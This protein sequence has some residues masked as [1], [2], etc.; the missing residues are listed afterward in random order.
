MEKNYPLSPNDEP[1]KA[2]ITSAELITFQPLE[3]NSVIYEDILLPTALNVD[4][5]G[6]PPLS[7]TLDA[8]TSSA[9][10]SISPPGTTEQLTGYHTSIIDMMK[11]H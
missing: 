2:N 7:S 5:Q 9:Y 1:P 11:Q 4:E 6:S 10:A 3:R 8:S